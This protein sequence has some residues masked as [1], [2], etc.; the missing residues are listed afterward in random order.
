MFC[1]NNP[2]GSTTVE[3]RSQGLWVPAF[4]GTTWYSIHLPVLAGPVRVA[5]MAAQDFAGGVARQRIEELDR[6]RRLEAGNA[7][8]G[9]GDDVGRAG[10]LARLHHH[11]GLDRLAPLLV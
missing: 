9:E 4:A 7:R 8:A 11:D 10:L 6:F 1:E 3:L 5:Q 2:R